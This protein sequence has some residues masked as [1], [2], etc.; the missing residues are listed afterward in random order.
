MSNEQYEAGPFFYITE[1]E[2][3]LCVAINDDEASEEVW[4]PLHWKGEDVTFRRKGVKVWVY[5]PESL[6]TEKGLV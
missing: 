5:A 4:L 2:K 6:L 3:A 1:T